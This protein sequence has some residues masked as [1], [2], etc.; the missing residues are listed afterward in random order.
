M[1]ESTLIRGVAEWLVDQ[2]LGNPDIFTMFRGAC[3]RINA[4]G[5]PISRAMITYQTLHPTI[6][7]EMAVWRR[8]KGVELEQYAPRADEPQSWRDSPLKF[9]L[10]SNMNMFRRRL[11]GPEATHDFPVLQSFADN[12]Y[13]DY[14]AM[15]TEFQTHSMIQVNNP[16]GILISWCTD[17]PSGFSDND[18]NALQRIQRR[19][20]VS[21]KTVIQSNISR[22][23]A[24]TYLGPRAAEKVLS[25]NIHR[26][27]GEVTRAVVW[28]SDMHGS[29][30]LADTMPQEHY[31]E[32][33][34]D[35]F[36][37]SAG[38]VQAAGGEVLEFIGDA[39]L[40]IFPVESDQDIPK[41]AESA[42]IAVQDALSRGEQCNS[43]RRVAG[44]ATFDFS[45]AVTL[46]EVMFGNIGIAKR[47]SFSVIGPTVNEASRI[48]KLTRTLNV[49]A[50]ATASV[51]NATPGFWKRG[52]EHQ[53]AG[54]SLP[55]C[56]FDWAA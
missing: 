2:S 43:E 11:T 38:A 53:L 3:E 45:I 7:I 21:C 42:S 32:L 44:K 37:S 12:G 13:T 40:A 8:G 47:L 24:E 20:A 26:G 56:L 51:A 16:R 39:V 6:D 17:R 46:G 19:F 49:K 54:V 35:Y 14:Y 27:D 4:A 50:L 29:T 1:G 34:N 30:R 25:G 15:A 23:I 48:E 9:M 22:N 18:I 31:L 36:E 33:L 55:V 52:Q 10:D 28:Y 41:A 5:V